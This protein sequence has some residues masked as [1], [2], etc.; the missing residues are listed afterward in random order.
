M[1]ALSTYIIKMEIV[2]LSHVR[3]VQK[4]KYPTSGLGEGRCLM[5]KIE[6]HDLKFYSKAAL[7]FF[8]SLAAGLFCSRGCI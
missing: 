1:Q 7:Y 3:D 5:G 8:L 4:M 6:K 2:P